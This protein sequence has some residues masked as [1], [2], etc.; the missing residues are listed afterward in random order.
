MESNSEME[1]ALK[2]YE[3]ANDILS[4]VRVY[5]FCGNIEKVQNSYTMSVGRCRL[6]YSS[7]FV[8]GNMKSHI[9]YLVVIWE[10]GNMGVSLHVCGSCSSSLV[11]KTVTATKWVRTS[12]TNTNSPS[13]DYT[14]LHEHVIIKI[15]LH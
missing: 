12:V 15:Q 3:A 4:V 2:Y 6:R 11:F 9:E 10:Y 13:Q 5:C 14:N 1:V 7:P 8:S